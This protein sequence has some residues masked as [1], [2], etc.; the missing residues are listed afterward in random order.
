MM[1]HPARLII[2]VLPMQK[3]LATMIGI[4]F[5]CVCFRWQREGSEMVLFRC[6]KGRLLCMQRNLSE[7]MCTISLKV[8]HK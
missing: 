1:I 6:N 7:D 4:F 8:F 5:Q 2:I 3:L